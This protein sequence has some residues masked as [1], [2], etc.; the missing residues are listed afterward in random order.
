M[1]ERIEITAS[2]SI[3][4]SEVELSF[5]RSSGPGGQNVNKVATAV[6][7]R[8]DAA[9]SRSLPDAVRTRLIAQAGSRATKDGVIVL[10][11]DRH[12]TQP[13]NREDAINRLAEMI[14]AAT[15]I[16]RKRRA[17]KPTLAS[18]RR[19]MDAKTRRGAIKAI[20]G[21]KPGFD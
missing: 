6:Q 1:P 15:Q 7:L 4:L 3:P 19:R 16:P 20:R 5:V 9:A 17:T 13:L 18:K 10:T 8:F 21:S 14:R 11:A 2:L 12:R